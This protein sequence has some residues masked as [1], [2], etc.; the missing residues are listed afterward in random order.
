MTKINVPLHGFGEFESLQQAVNVLKNNNRWYSSI[1]ADIVLYN[2]CYRDHLRKHGLM[3]L[4]QRLISEAP[5]LKDDKKA[6]EQLHKCFLVILE[7]WCF[8]YKPLLQ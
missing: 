7:F 2:V 3:S 1:L 4:E 8:G 6:L 5:E